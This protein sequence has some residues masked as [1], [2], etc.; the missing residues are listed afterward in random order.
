MGNIGNQVIAGV[1][2]GYGF[3]SGQQP[4]RG[5]PSPSLQAGGGNQSTVSGIGA[6][7]ALTQFQA[8][9]T[10]LESGRLSLL[11]LDTLVLV[12]IGFYFWTRKI[13]GG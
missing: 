8:G 6:G 12:L 3:A 9:L 11:M 7:S 10:D 5:V 4:I 1:R 13:Q 2:G